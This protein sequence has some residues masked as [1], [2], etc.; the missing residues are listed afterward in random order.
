MIGKITSGASG[1]ALIRYLFGPGK[2]NEH[3]DERV[4]TSGLALGGDVLACGNLVRPSD[5]RARSGP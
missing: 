1:R 3:T 5:R 2:A 4:I